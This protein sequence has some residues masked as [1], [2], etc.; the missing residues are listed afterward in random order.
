MGPSRWRNE[1][2]HR[3]S[4]K[5]L[6]DEGFIEVSV[7]QKSSW[8]QSSVFVCRTLRFRRTA[9]WLES[10][11]IDFELCRIELVVDLPTVTATDIDEVL[12]EGL[13]LILSR[14]SSLL[15]GERLSSVL[16][17]RY[18]KGPRLLLEMTKID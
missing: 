2:V 3:W 7:L 10:R 12:L 11:C 8:A 14:A 16:W 1:T 5:L 13:K 17:N 18:D 15:L 4:K 6:T 9:E